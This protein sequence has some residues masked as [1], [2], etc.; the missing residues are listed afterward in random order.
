MAKVAEELVSVSVTSNLYIYSILL[1][2]FK[3]QGILSL[4]EERQEPEPSEPESVASATHTQQSQS[5]SSTATAPTAQIVD[6]PTV[7]TPRSLHSH[8]FTFLYEKTIA[9]RPVPPPSP[10][11]VTS[12]SSVNHP[13]L[14]RRIMPHKIEIELLEYMEMGLPSILDKEGK[15][16]MIDSLGFW[17]ENVARFP[18]LSKLGFSL[19]SLQCSSTASERLFSI[20]GWHCQGRK[21]RLEKENLAAKVFLT[22]NKDLLRS[23]IF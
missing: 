17:K 2:Y 6:D 18:H 16:E 12:S 15:P 10:S 4:S 13:A 1:Y 22:C 3:I 11:L 23:H 19:L 21:N 14:S 8:S 5:Q 7:P 9:S 20:A